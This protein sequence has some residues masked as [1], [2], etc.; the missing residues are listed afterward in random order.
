M[1]VMKGLL[2][3]VDE[4]LSTSYEPDCE[5]VDGILVE[6]NVGRRTHSFWQ[7]RL[8]LFLGAREAK[9]RIFTFT[10]WRMRIGPTRFRIPDVTV[11]RGACPADE[12]LR[13]PPFLVIEI[14]SPDDKQ[15]ELQKKIHDYRAFGIPYILVIY[16]DEPR[17]VL[18]TKDDEQ[19][20]ANGVLRTES[21]AIEIPLM[22][23]HRGIQDLLVP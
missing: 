4:Y 1:A 19:E 14:W 9:W 21:P 11:V 13:E 6:R 15:S 22:E 3:S 2:V 7:S 12:I 17:F 18:F 5:Y 16:P 20:L 8:T 23:I 10:E